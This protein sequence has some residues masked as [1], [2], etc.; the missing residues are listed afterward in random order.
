MQMP[1]YLMNLSIVI[2]ECHSLAVSLGPTE[3]KFHFFYLV[4]EYLQKKIGM[5][6]GVFRDGL[7]EM[8][9]KYLKRKSGVH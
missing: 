5:D 3:L 7:T 4:G 9:R 8:I 6:R 1:V 2:E